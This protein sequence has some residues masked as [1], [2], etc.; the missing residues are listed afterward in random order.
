VLIDLLLWPLI[1]IPA[2]LAGLRLMPLIGLAGVFRRATDGAFFALWLGLLLI[3]N[4]LLAAALF[5]PLTPTLIALLGIVLSLISLAHREVRA[6]A[7]SLLRALSAST[8]L[9]AA[10][11]AVAVAAALI[12]A[13]PIYW[14]DSGL[15]HI[16]AIK[17]LS[18]IGTVRGVALIHERFGFVSSWFAAPAALNHGILA[19]RTGALLNGFVLLA[20]TGFLLVTLR[21]W[22]RGRHDRAD[23]LFAAAA[24]IVLLFCLQYGLVSSPSP[25][26]PIAALTM[27][28]AWSYLAAREDA[29]PTAPVVLL[30]GAVTIK[31]SAAVLLAAS[32]AILVFKLDWKQRA[33][34]LVG[35]AIVL[36]PVLASSF[37]AS[38]CF[39]YPFALSCT[40]AD[41]SLG[42]DSARGMVPRIA[43]FGRWGPSVPADANGWSWIPGWP[44]RRLANVIFSALL[45]LSLVAVLAQWRAIRRTAAV[46]HVAIVAFA[47]I[48]YVLATS[49][50]IRFAIGAL[51]IAPAL[52]MSELVVGR[53]LV[54]ARAATAGIVLGLLAAAAMNS[55]R[56]GQTPSR[57]G[58]EA[59]AGIAPHAVL[60]PLAARLGRP[61][62][63]DPDFT[64]AEVAQGFAIRRTGEVAYTI[65]VP[66]GLCWDAPLPCAT[67]MLE[68]PIRLRDPARGLAGGFAKAAP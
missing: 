30:I 12:A 2:L 13:Q 57:S 61:L 27:L 60:P 25:D 7:G 4:L 26:F 44:L 59:S 1:A 24:T 28:A 3:V 15:Y 67:E 45:G 31:L 52:L 5:I 42:A 53:D 63:P 34:L 23:I 43:N 46:R 18:A 68:R 14:E 50:E 47:G 16:Q 6:Q 36:L 11:A 66:I 62:D 21:R 32:A 51:A 54:S 40:E 19:G 49:P 48:A 39:I 33:G 35:P 41:W 22:W 17:W 37:V 58:L 64:A 38:G 56:L 10:I 65:P 29:V 20:M 9:L 8:P 55:Y